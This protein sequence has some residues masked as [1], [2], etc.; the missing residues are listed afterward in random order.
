MAEVIRRRFRKYDKSAEIATGPASVLAPKPSGDFPDLVMIDGGK[1]QLSAV[2][3]VLREMNLLEDVKVVSLAKQREEIF[4]PG[5]SL[6][7]E[8]EAETA[9]SAALAAAAGRG[10][11]ICGQLSPP[12][13][14]R[15]DAAFAAR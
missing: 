10:A 6:P 13:A 8:T 4:L 15:P 7:L 14:Q 9:R 2:V 1:G 12:A 5:E 3:E 11:P